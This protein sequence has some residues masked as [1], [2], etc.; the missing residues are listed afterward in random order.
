M[1]KEMRLLIMLSFL[2]ILASGLTFAIS[3]SF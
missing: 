3:N 2:F 1:K